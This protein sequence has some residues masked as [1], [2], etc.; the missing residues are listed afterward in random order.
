MINKGGRVLSTFSGPF[1]M[2]T[3]EQMTE[4]HRLRLEI[5]KKISEVPDEGIVIPY[6]GKEFRVYRTV[7]W[8]WQDSKPLIENYVINPGETVLDVCTGSGVIAVFSA[9][10]GAKKVVAVD[11]NPDAV[12][13]AKEN[14]GRHGFSDVIDVRV[15]DMFAAIRDD[16]IFDVITGNLP[17]TRHDAKSYAECTVYDT[18]LRVHRAFFWNI[19]SHLNQNGRAYLSQANFGALEDMV[20]LA[21]YAGFSVNKIGTTKMPDNDPREFYAFEIKRK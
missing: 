8:P 1:N 13:S 4:V 19:R 17:F 9:Y 12:R 10:K 20:D 6:L 5:L 18:D 11:I 2:L 16:E 3:K 21:D 14:A 15:S 7:F